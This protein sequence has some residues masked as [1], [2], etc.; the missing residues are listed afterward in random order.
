MRSCG[1]R[2]AGPKSTGAFSTAETEVWRGIRESHRSAW[3]SASLVGPALVQL[4]AGG[5]IQLGEANSAVSRP[6][7]GGGPD[8]I[9]KSGKLSV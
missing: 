9:N 3:K 7:P 6:N 4:S 8:S 5:I 1:G 2:G